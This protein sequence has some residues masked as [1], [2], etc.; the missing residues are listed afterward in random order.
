M[1]NDISSFILISSHHLATEGYKLH[2]RGVEI[3]PWLVWVIL[4]K[5][6]NMQVQMMIL[7]DSQYAVFVLR[8]DLE[9]DTCIVDLRMTDRFHQDITMIQKHY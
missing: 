2:I 7:L 9:Y 1:E 6:S 8:Q 5:T 4:M 3:P